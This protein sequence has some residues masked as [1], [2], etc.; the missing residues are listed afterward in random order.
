M[1]KVDFDKEFSLFCNDNQSSAIKDIYAI[2]PTL[3]NSQIRVINA[4]NFYIN[5]YDLQDLKQLIDQYL[6]FI[7]KNKNLNF[8]RSMNVKNLLRAYTQEELVRGIK[9]NANNINQVGD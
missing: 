7:K 1:P 4:L 8:I 2:I 5:K 9:V 3:D 6:D